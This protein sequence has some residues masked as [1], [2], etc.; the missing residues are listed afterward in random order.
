MET[1]MKIVR[2]VACA[3]ALACSVAAYA[4]S[5]YPTKPITMIVPGPP[6]SAIDNVA[7]VIGEAMTASLG[8]NILALNVEGAGATLGTIRLAQAQP[9]GYTIL[10]HN[11]GLAVAPALYNKLQY[12]VANDLQPLG[13]TSEVPILLVAKLDLPPKNVR[14][15]I[16]YLKKE[17]KNISLATSGPGSASDLCGTVFQ[18]MLGVNFT[19]VPYK[20]SSP[21]LTDMIGGRIDLMCDQTTSAASQIKAGRI[22]A[23][24]AATKERLPILPDVPTMTEGG[25]PYEF[26]IWQGMYA[27]ART[28]ADIVRKLSIALRSAIQQEKVKEA[29]STK[30]SVSTVD[31]E[32][33]TPEFHTRFLKQEVERWGKYY[34]SV[35]KE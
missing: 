29:L 14:D 12:D 34:K 13:L 24:G 33:A 26:S 35:P 31:L 20:G 6:G 5:A 28:P 19:L 32:R 17:G 18:Q 1:K 25:M 10:F 27:P 16:P 21:A 3:I 11:V 7:R 2:T 15:L 4:Q 8:Q 30:Y 9:D 22:K 23:Y